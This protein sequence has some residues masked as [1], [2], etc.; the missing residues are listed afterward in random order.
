[1][2]LNASD[3]NP[4]SLSG[5]VTVNSSAGTSSV[6][7]A[8]DQLTEGPEKFVIKLRTGSIT[9]PVVAVSNQV[10]IN[11]T[12][13]NNPT[14]SFQANVASVSEGQSVKFT[15]I[16]TDIPSGTVI[17]YEIV[18]NGI[19]SA[20]INGA[21]LSGNFTVNANGTATMDLTLTTTADLTTEGNETLTI[22]LTT[23]PNNPS[24]SITIVDSSV[25]PPVV[26]TYAL[27]NNVSNAANEGTSV[28]FNLNV[29]NVNVGTSVPYTITGISSADI[30]N[31][32]L[33]G[34][35]VVTNNTP[36][37]TA[38]FAISADQLTEGSETMTMTLDGRSVSS[39]VVISDTSITPVL[40]PT[41]SLSA[42]P[43]SVNEGSTVTFTLT[44]TNVTNG[45]TLPFTVSGIQQTDITGLT[46]DSGTSKFTG[47]FTVTNNTASV[48]V[49]VVSDALTEG[50]ETMTMTLTNNQATT[51]VSINDTSGTPVVTGS[52]TITAANTRAVSVTLPTAAT[53]VAFRVIGA[54]GSG[55]GPD[56]GSAG[57]SGGGGQYARGIVKLPATTGP[58]ALYGFVGRPGRGGRKQSKIVE[59][60]GIGEN[61]TPTADASGAIGQTESSTGTSGGGGAGGGASSFY[62]RAPDGTYVP[63]VIV[64]GGGGGGGGT[65][66]RTDY[67][68]ANTANKGFLTFGAGVTGTTTATGLA[69]P[70]SSSDGGGGGGGGGAA[71]AAGE[72]GVDKTIGSKGG[73]AGYVVRNDSNGLTWNTFDWYGIG[74][75]PPSS[76][77]IA[78]EAPQPYPWVLFGR[79]GRGAVANSFTEDGQGKGGQMGA[80]AFYWT[81][82]TTAPSYTNI[83][84]WAYPVVSITNS[85]LA[86]RDMQA[87]GT[88]LVTFWSW[89]AVSYDIDAN[90]STSCFIVHDWGNDPINGIGE[91]LE[92]RVVTSAPSNG[93]QRGVL[94]SNLTENTWTAMTPNWEYGYFVGCTEGYI[95]ATVAIRRR[96]DGTVLRTVTYF[97]ITGPI[98]SYSGGY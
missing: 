55:G 32:S 61:C 22:R 60:G 37:A 82:D 16:T 87:I 93:L 36:S 70:Y 7:I 1:M 97:N 75:V 47:T 31:V 91:F 92:I 63:I 96:D 35:F 46:W 59:D 85:S 27:S 39:Y 73:S 6:V 84:D 21:P 20:D 29:T 30:G 72:N 89:G 48:T 34:N 74:P 49:S 40:P 52:G 44:T 57:G 18:G 83:P 9:G 65:W 2:T 66:N 86:G 51:S 26:P 4:A 43:T 42:N 11:D 38:T 15:L 10:T 67:G 17:P 28:T 90:R 3:F 98:S 64:G 76:T 12:S 58:K 41:Y 78:A 45:T 50:G 77:S 80:I 69:A 23:A 68:L 53:W 19:T 62:Y 24:V 81:T 56:Q 95:N 25:A 14:Y 94:S 79:G 13:V 33:T 54:G 71:G 5:T 88:S 8:A